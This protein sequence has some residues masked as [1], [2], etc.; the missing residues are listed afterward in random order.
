MLGR[1]GPSASGWKGG[2]TTD[3]DGYIKTLAHDHPFHPRNGGYVREHVRVME[4]AIGRRLAPQ[5]VVHHKNH[6]KH[7]NRLENLQLMTNREHARLH[8]ALDMHTRLRVDGRLARK[9]GTLKPPPTHCPNGHPYEGRN[10]RVDERGIRHCRQC[11]RDI[12]KVSYLKLRDGILA[13]RRANYVPRALQVV[14]RQGDREI[15][16]RIVPEGE[17]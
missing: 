2:V 13:R 12:N 15:T 14:A 9:D 5:E 1:T 10:V 7:D 6:D 16:C 11:R 8:R 4:L 3:R 17:V